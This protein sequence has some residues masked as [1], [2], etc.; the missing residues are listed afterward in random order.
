MN[1]IRCTYQ[2]KRNDA[3]KLEERSI[4]INDDGIDEEEHV[5]QSAHYEEDVEARYPGCVVHDL[6]VPEGRPLAMECLV[7]LWV[8]DLL[9]RLPDVVACDGKTEDESEE[10]SEGGVVGQLFLVCANLSHDELD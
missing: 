6:L 7:Y 2:I 4:A 5:D 3:R 1:N 8:F 10:E 9:L